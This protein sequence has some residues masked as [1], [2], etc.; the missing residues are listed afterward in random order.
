MLK[1]D[2]TTLKVFLHFARD[3]DAQNKNYRHGEGKVVK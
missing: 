3:G 1:A 2:D